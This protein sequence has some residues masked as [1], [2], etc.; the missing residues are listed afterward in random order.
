[1]LEASFYEDLSSQ[2]VLHHVLPTGI[3]A[4]GLHNSFVAQKECA[5]LCPIADHD[6]GHFDL[7][8]PRTLVKGDVP[9][10]LSASKQRPDK[11]KILPLMSMG[12]NDRRH[13]Q[14]GVRLS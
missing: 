13:T 3:E 1:M 2:S 14:D 9:P 11:V 7:K 6:K 4:I 5:Q 8:D 10:A 12:H